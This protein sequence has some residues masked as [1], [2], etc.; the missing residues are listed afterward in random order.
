MESQRWIVGK[1]IP[2]DK[3][4]LSS[5]GVSSDGHT[6]FLYLVTPKQKA[7][8]PGLEGERPLTMMSDFLRKFCQ[9]HRLSSPIGVRILCSLLYLLL[10]RAVTRSC[11]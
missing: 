6:I 3:A 11:I 10:F 5:C 4:S 2:D 1:R 9:V 7:L 8:H